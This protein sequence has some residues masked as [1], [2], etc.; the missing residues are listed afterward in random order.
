MQGPCA[1]QENK[2]TMIV[3]IPRTVLFPVEDK[4]STSGNM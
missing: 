2:S 1:H 4:L 3:M